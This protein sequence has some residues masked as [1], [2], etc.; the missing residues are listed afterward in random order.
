[1]SRRHD[2]PAQEPEG[3]WIP[4]GSLERVGR[5]IDE[6]LKLVPPLEPED[7][8][9]LTCVRVER[10]FIAE[11]LPC[12]VQLGKTGSRR[13][14][15]HRCAD[16]AVDAVLKAR[17]QLAVEVG[18]LPRVITTVEYAN[19]RATAWW[20]RWRL[21]LCEAV[22]RA[23]RANWSGDPR[24]RD[25]LLAIECSPGTFDRGC[26]SGCREQADASRPAFSRQS[27]W[28]RFCGSWTIRADALQKVPGRT[29]RAACVSAHCGCETAWRKGS[30]RRGPCWMRNSPPGMCRF[31]ISHPPQTSRPW[32]K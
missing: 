7:A 15:L 6:L 9:G 20:T 17:P 10:E 16:L 30:R 31:K 1:M 4:T 21:V 32:L 29:E 13:Q 11:L 23:Q 22:D 12:N 28:L 8:L 3:I 2:T 5:F 25:G 24:T 18:A 27:L 19:V 14:V 26:D